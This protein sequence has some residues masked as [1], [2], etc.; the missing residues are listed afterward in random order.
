MR[1]QIVRFLLT[2]LLF[3]QIVLP[4]ALAQT[5]ETQTA[6]DSL[7][8]EK[9]FVEGSPAPQRDDIAHSE[10]GQTP[11][12]LDHRGP[13]TPVPPRILYPRTASPRGAW[14]PRNR[15]HALIGALIGF[16]IGAALGAKGNRDQHTSARIAAP[17]LVGGVGAL[18]G[19]AVGSSVP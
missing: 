17:I 3:M 19:A 7:T 8:A 14:Q 2:S 11:T 12:E 5:R 4:C 9:V 15:R 18:I 6:N 10:A 13:V 16:G 1:Q